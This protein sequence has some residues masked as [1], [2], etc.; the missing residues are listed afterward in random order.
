[1]LLEIKM[2]YLEKKM[3]AKMR[4]KPEREKE[5]ETFPNIR[6][7]FDLDTK[8]SSFKSLT[9]FENEKP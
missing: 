8:R 3:A 9:F 2:K 4:T 7:F 6:L 1:M 5:R